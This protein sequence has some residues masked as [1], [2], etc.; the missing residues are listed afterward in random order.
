MDSLF[1]VSSKIVQFLIEPL[2]LIFIAI[3]LA[4]YYLV[5]LKPLATKR[6]L[7]ASLIG[8]IIVGYAPIPESLIR[9]LEDAIPKSSIE[10]LQPDQFAGIIIL[11]GAISGEDIAID[12][13]EVVIGDAAE[14][15]T[16]GLELIR[17][18]PNKPFF[19]LVFLEG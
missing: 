2:N 1:F 6:L 7:E 3:F 13:G 9:I 5:I 18:F 4:L 11:G 16:K 14:R 12:R 10:Q 15:V 8:F 17:K 19:L